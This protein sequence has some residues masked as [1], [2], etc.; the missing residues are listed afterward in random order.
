MTGP[1][2]HIRDLLDVGSGE[3]FS[4]TFLVKTKDGS[5]IEFPFRPSPEQAASAEAK[6]W[7]V[8]KCAPEEV[9]ETPFSPAA[10]PAAECPSKHVLETPVALSAQPSAELVQTALLETPRRIP[11][12]PFN[13][14]GPALFDRRASLTRQQSKDWFK[15][16]A[17]EISMDDQEN[18]LD[19]LRDDSFMRQSDRLRDHTQLQAS[20]VNI[21]DCEDIATEDHSTTVAEKSKCEGSDQ[22]DPEAIRQRSSTDVLVI[23]VNNNDPEDVST[24]DHSTT[25][26]EKSKCE[27]S[28]Q[29]DPDATCQRNTTEALATKAQKPSFSKLRPPAQKSHHFSAVGART[30]SCMNGPASSLESGLKTN[31]P[32]TSEDDCPQPKRTRPEVKDGGLAQGCDSSQQA[33]VQQ[34][35]CSALNGVSKIP[36]IQNTQRKMSGSSKAGSSLLERRRAAKSSSIPSYDHKSAST[37]R[38]PVGPRKAALRDAATTCISSNSQMISKK[39]TSKS[40]VINNKRHSANKANKVLQQV[41]DSA[42]AEQPHLSKTAREEWQDCGKTPKRVQQKPSKNEESDEVGMLPNPDIF[43]FAFQGSSKVQ[44]SPAVKQAKKTP[45][46]RRKTAAEIHEESQACLPALGSKWD[47]GGKTLF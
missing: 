16:F 21:N 44:N 5:D 27:G 4:P 9:K 6:A 38:P 30:N 35:K 18:L 46:R 31:G 10:Q 42:T 14:R 47:T 22:K 12:S 32:R 37:S 28:D 8:P 24:E 1:S 26:A 20:F 36:A 13:S 23:K 17:K 19:D 11:L 25:V 33:I 34:T 7:N 15:P 40:T 29:K 39:S 2:I 41:V 3:T 45:M 43:A